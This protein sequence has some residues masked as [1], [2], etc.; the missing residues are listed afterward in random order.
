MTICEDIWT[1]DYLQRPFYDRDP[2]RELTA[3]GIDLLLNLSASP[4]HLGKPAQRR[5]M[6]GGVAANAWRREQTW[7]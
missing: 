3:Q 6:I 2:V 7:S 5:A 4:F 1:E